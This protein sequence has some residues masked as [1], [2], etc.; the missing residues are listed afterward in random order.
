[1][2]L[3]GLS[4]LLHALLL[5]AMLMRSSAAARVQFEHQCRPYYVAGFNVDNGTLDCFAGYSSF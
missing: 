3:M 2:Q 4:P 1:M 5:L